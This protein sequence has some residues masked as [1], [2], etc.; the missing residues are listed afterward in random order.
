VK[1]PSSLA[2]CEQWDARDPFAQTR[3][4]FHLK[5]GLIYMDGN[6]LG[7]MTAASMEHARAM[8]QDEWGRDLIRSW[9][10]HGWF[11][12]PLRLGAKI[13][14]LIGA[15]EDEVLVADS[16]SV[17]IF[18]LASAAM[19]A[20]G[21][22]RR[23]VTELGNFPSDNYVL[24]GLAQLSGGAIEVVAVPREELAVQINASTFLVVLTH[25]HYKSAELLDLRATTQL[26]HTHGAQILWD[27][28]HSV[29]AMPIQLNLAK[30][31]FA[32]GCT[33][34]YL[35]GGPGSPAFMYVRRD[36]QN[37][38][39]PGLTAWMGHAAPFEFADDYEPAP[40]MA[41]FRGGTPSMISFA[42]LDGA[43]DLWD[44][45]DLNE[46]RR[47]SEALSELFITR[48]EALTRS[49][50][51]LA[52][53]R[54]ASRRGS[55]IAL[56]HPQGYELMQAMIAR[57]VIGDFR[58]PDIVRFAFTPLYQRYVDVWNAAEILVEVL[59]HLNPAEHV[60]RNAVT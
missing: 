55:H 47:K 29:G 45:I 44:D 31:D 57:G 49:G 9:N 33:Y 3:A 22:R 5:H 13:A 43:L 27:L 4:Q 23:I 46:V 6:S 15:A 58:A 50:L 8:I 18:K 40:G 35:N 12:L 51:T 32:V 48:I 24:Q 10:T 1:L 16:T 52:S 53:P 26:A 39:Q 19:M 42:A 20:R 30:A 36:L 25:A 28:S 56:A 17:N 60:R 14:P 59:A 34:K 21:A 11:D 38:L 41:R 37:A 54:D 2:E 7:A